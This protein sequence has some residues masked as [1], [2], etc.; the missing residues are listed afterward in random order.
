MATPEQPAYRKAVFEARAHA[1]EGAVAWARERRKRFSI[2]AGFG[3]SFVL[4]GGVTG[5]YMALDRVSA[6]AAGRSVAI[7]LAGPLAGPSASRTPERAPARRGAV[8]LALAEMTGLQIA[9]PPL[10]PPLAPPLAVPE[11][12]AA[13]S[14][15]QRLLLGGVLAQLSDTVRNPPR[16]P[17]ARNP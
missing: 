14:E 11:A 5:G 4:L 13:G 10:G 9:L 2:W 16:N 17:P 6:G 15:T 1:R 12:P 3:L 8:R 7:P